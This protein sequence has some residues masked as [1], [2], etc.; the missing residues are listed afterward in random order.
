[1]HQF[2]SSFSSNKCSITT[3]SHLTLD[4]QKKKK[5]K[6]LGLFFFFLMLETYLNSR[7]PSFYLCDC[8]QVTKFIGDFFPPVLSNETQAIRSVSQSCC[9]DEMMAWPSRQCFQQAGTVLMSAEEMCQRPEEHLCKQ[10]F[11]PI[12]YRKRQQSIF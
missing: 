10:R 4:R 11:C 2:A 8:G 5:S 9:N 12:C 3:E 7:C 6:A 1:M